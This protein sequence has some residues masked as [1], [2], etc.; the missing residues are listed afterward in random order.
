MPAQQRGFARRRGKKWLA[1]WYDADGRERTRGGFETKT[2]ALKYAAERADA[3]T[4]EAASR[5]FGDSRLVVVERPESVDA[6]LDLFLEKHGA[7]VDAATRKKLETQLR[8]AR[9]VFGDRH[10]ESL[11][12]LELEDWQND[13]SPG[14]RHDVFRAFRQALTWGHDRNL[15]TRNA[16]DGIKNPKRKREDRKPILPFESWEEIDAIEAELDPLYIGLPTFATGSGLRPEE[17]TA[18]ERTDVDLANRYVIVNK[19]YSGGQL[20][21]GTKN[22]V[23]ERRVPLRERV[24]EALSRRATRID[25]PLLFPAPRGG[26]ID[27]ERFRYREWTPALRAAGLAHRGPNHCRHT[28]ATWAIISGSVQTA[29]LAVLMG[30]SV[31]EIEDT[32]FRW[33]QSADERLVK[34]FDAFDARAVG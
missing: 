4:A 26:Y 24:V 11:A 3:A 19:R 30:T 9:A 10:P 14:S 12:R 18:L 13:L 31:K 25:T 8:R 27:I 34:A 23:A 15:T 16:T 32:Y 33:L 5:R 21:R 28:F 6:L 2:H 7:R 1:C 29:E 22:G 17:W 20:K